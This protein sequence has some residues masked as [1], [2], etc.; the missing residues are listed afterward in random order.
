MDIVI[1]PYK[2]EDAAAFAE[3]HYDAVHKLAKDHYAGYILE[4][5][6]GPVDENRLQEIRNSA[7]DERRIMAEAEGRPV[8][9]GC[10]IP[11]KAE[12]RACYVHSAYA[13]KG[14]GSRIVAEL[15][16]IAVDYNVPELQLDASLNAQKFYERNGYSSLGKVMHSSRRS[17]MS[18]ECV[19]M[20]KTIKE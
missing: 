17:G 8:G 9:I 16:K 11:E 12:L 2:P 19:R 20:K 18:V 3:I 1:R 15:E 6:S 5:W 10:I 14:V 4:D 7:R 13:G